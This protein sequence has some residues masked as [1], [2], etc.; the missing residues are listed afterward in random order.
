MRII[1]FPCEGCKLFPGCLFPEQTG[2]RPRNVQI[3]IQKFDL[4]LYQQQKNN[5]FAVK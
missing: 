4:A 1:K 2:S 5:L 3:L